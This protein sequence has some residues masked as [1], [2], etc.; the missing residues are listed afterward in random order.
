[1]ADKEAAAKA[2]E[3][4]KPD[5]DV[6]E[7]DADDMEAIQHIIQAISGKDIDLVKEAKKVGRNREGDLVWIPSDKWQPLVDAV[8]QVN[9]P[10]PKTDP[11]V[12][13]SDTDEPKKTEPK[14]EEAAEDSG[15][16]ADT[17]PP[18]AKPAVPK[19]PKIRRAVPPKQ[20]KQSKPQG[21]DY[22]SLVEQREQW[23]QSG[24]TVTAS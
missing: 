8:E 3:D 7:L 23:A 24:E 4:T 19:M 16:T 17:E 6:I 2:A 14:A 20:T 12:K 9:N 5:E 18:P 21:D 11:K 15:K 13:D 10:K 1:M 22:Q